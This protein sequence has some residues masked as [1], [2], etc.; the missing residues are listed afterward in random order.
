MADDEE[1]EKN[2]QGGIE[3]IV[4]QVATG[5]DDTA[6]PSEYPKDIYQQKERIVS[7]DSPEP[8]KGPEDLQ[9]AHG[10]SEERPPLPSPGPDER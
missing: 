7:A 10:S 3:N 4:E 1:L 8:L 9:E 5:K 6:E 2:L